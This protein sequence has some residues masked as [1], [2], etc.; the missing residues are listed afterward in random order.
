MVP[1]EGLHGYKEKIEPLPNDSPSPTELNAGAGAGDSSNNTMVDK[2]EKEG[3]GKK[4]FK[5]T[6]TKKQFVSIL[7]FNEVYV[8]MGIR[9]SS[10]Q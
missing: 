3:E 7:Y 10:L 1:I 8:I 4:K 5:P 2:E 9:K 6:V